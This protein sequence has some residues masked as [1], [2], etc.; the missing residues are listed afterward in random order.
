MGELS[1]SEQALFAKP[2]LI[3]DIYKHML[4]EYFKTGEITDE[5]ISKLQLELEETDNN[6]DNALRQI[7]K[8]HEGKES[9]VGFFK[10]GETQNGI[11]RLHTQ[12]KTA[13]S[14][15]GFFDRLIYESLVPEDTKYVESQWEDNLSGFEN[16]TQ[17]EPG[18]QK[19]VS[20]KP[21]TFISDSNENVPPGDTK[22]VSSQKVTYNQPSKPGLF[23]KFALK[24][25]VP[26][27]TKYVESLS[28]SEAD[29]SESDNDYY[30]TNKPV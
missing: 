16:G 20:I 9:S 3:E 11:Q 2:E 21:K 6:Q 24:F 18:P 25:L 12:R 19:F 5:Q 4:T 22:H 10:Y 15:L 30:R 29:S 7:I 13:S 26:E 14:K 8:K 1:E 17:R 23:D 27:D 28:E